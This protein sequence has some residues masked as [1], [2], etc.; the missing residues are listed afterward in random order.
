MKRMALG[1]AASVFF[2]SAAAHL[3]RF[4]FRWEVWI[5]SYEVPRW[6]SMTGFLAGLIL[7]L[8]MWAGLREDGKGAQQ[9][10]NM[11]DSQR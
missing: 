9:R 4:L 11:R 5:G 6:M 3:L 10:E 7:A 1:L 2:L 8:I